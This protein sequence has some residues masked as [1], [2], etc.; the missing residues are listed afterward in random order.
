MGSAERSE[1]LVVGA[2]GEGAVGTQ[3][4][5]KIAPLPVMQNTHL[6]HIRSPAGQTRPLHESGP[7]FGNLETVWGQCG[8]NLLPTHTALHLQRVRHC[9]IFV[10]IL[11][12]NVIPGLA[13]L[14]F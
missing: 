14:V 1:F 7:D 9:N 10:F 3:H 11:I 8:A 6:P 4:G 13:V 5:M 2:E 12:S